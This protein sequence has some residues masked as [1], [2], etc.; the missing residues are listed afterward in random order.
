[1]PVH[2]NGS[3]NFIMSSMSSESTS[4]DIDHPG[5]H[6]LRMR[7]GHRVRA[8]EREEEGAIVTLARYNNIESC[9]YVATGEK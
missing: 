5:L 4:K 9:P 1:M 2:C 8:L 3:Q 6:C 7:I